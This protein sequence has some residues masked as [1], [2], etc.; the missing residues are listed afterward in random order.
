MNRL[1]LSG[2]LTGTMLLPNLVTGSMFSQIPENKPNVV[3]IFADDMGYGDLGCYGATQYRTPNID[4]LANQGIRFTDFLVPSAVCTASRAGLMTGCYPNRVGL[5]GALNPHAT[6]GLKPEEET[7]AEVFKKADYKTIAIGKWHLGHLEEFLPTNQGFDEYLGIPYSNDM[8]PFTYDNIRAT[9]ET[10]PRKA[11]F[12][13]L[14]LI[15]NTKKVKEFKSIEDQA[16]ITTIYTQKAVE[17]IKGNKE[18]PFFLYLAH[19]MP[20]VPLAV[21][22]KF[23]NRSKQGLYGDV[24]MEIDWSVGEVVKTLKEC[25][26]YENTLLIF[27]S[28]NGPWFN[29]GNHAG[30]AGGLREGKGTSWEGGNRVPCIMVWPNVIPKGEICNQLSSTIDILPTVSEILNVPLEGR[31]IDGVNIYPLLTGDAGVSPRENFLYYYRD[32][33]LEAVRWHNWKLVFPH[34]G[35]TYEGYAPGQ[36][37]LPGQTNENFMFEGGLFDLRRDPGERYD[38]M[39]TYPE[40]LEILTNIANEARIDL[41]DD[42]QGIKGKNIRD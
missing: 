8:W 5:S 27:T 4:N 23:M 42:L 7:I 29:F 3:I 18:N 9:N 30:S 13:E 41:G 16:Q 20:H 33:N 40:V 32:N 28:D 24:M 17:F 31:K 26:L 1:I 37:G 12:P 2:T 35:R 39:E 14:P 36:D 21:S 11:S 15:H 34:P 25:G 22:D 10:H 38:V 19:S 6:K